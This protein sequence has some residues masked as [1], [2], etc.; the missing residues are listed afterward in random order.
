MPLIRFLG[1]LKFAVALIAALA[2]LLTVSTVTESRFGTSFAQKLFYR[3]GWFD[4][5]LAL[6]GVNI[7]TSAALRWPFRRRHTGFLVTHAGILTLLAG[8]LLT[9]LF[10]V[11]GRMTLAEGEHSNRLVAE[12]HELLA[13]TSGDVPAAFDFAPRA[14]AGRVFRPKGAGFGLRVHETLDAAAET[15][16]IEEGA[17]GAAPNRAAE[18]VLSSETV[19]ARES[20]WLIER[21]PANPASREAAI[22]PARVQ[23]V[24]G[25]SAPRGPVL[26]IRRRGSDGVFEMPLADPPAAETPLLGGALT[27]ARVRYLEHALVDDNRLVDAPERIPFNP[28]VELEVRDAAGRSERHTRFALFP[29]F[30][31]LHGR[32]QDDRFGL[33]IELDAPLPET[34]RGGPLLQIV[35]GDGGWSY[36]ALSAKTGEVREGPL[37]A[38]RAVATGWM[39]FTLEAKSL[40]ERAE[41]RRTVEPAPRASAEHGP[42]ARI[43]VERGGAASE[44]RWVLAAGPAVEFAG[45]PPVR[46]ALRPKT[47]ELPFLLTLEDFR[48]TDYPG[49]GKAASFESDVILHDSGAK[50]WFTR[51]IRMNEPLDHAG[52]RVFQS[53]YFQ[54]LGAG[55][56]SVFTIA[57]NPGIVLIYAGASTIFLGIVLLFYISPFSSEG[58]GRHAG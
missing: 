9:R 15:L 58:P 56:G 23:L 47:F 27:L 16:R 42:A 34:A 33:E 19:G 31:S 44:P 10:G 17:P 18:I 54:D 45:E 49:T 29:D 22:G 37:E 20:F 39:D 43:S 21:D 46:V 28:A 13:S 50:A 26:R 7:F 11:E 53:S 14:G 48:K 36:R 32:T 55:E 4:L 30:P 12:G 25:P 38:G 8:S 35:A 5:F 51:T 24:A 57:K 52:W 6:L 40:F 41:V 3:A 1:S 2:V